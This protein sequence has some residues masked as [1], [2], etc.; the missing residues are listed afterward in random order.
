MQRRRDRNHIQM[1][2]LHTI[3]DNRVR[4]CH[5][6]IMVFGI[7]F[8]S[9]AN[10][11]WCDNVGRAHRSNGIYI[12]ADLLKHECFQRCFD[13]DCS[14]FRSLPTPFP[15][16]VITEIDAVLA[17]KQTTERNVEKSNE[18]NDTTAIPDTDIYNSMDANEN[19]FW[20]A[21]VEELD[22]GATS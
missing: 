8:N 14:H 15:Q 22:R 10:N 2:I 1:D 9:I 6:Y 13:P 3:Q 17:I 7:D 21:V 11:R 5:T 20:I 18:H 19:E 16:T 12:V 4:V